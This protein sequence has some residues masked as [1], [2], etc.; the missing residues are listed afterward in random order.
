MRSIRVAS[1][2]LLSTAAFAL[3]APIASA[4]DGGTTPNVTSFGF[5]VSPT[6]VAAG[7]TV[8]L[9]A[10]GC[11][12]PLVKASSGI[13]DAVEL[14][15]GK[16]ATATVDA[17][18]KPG[19]QYEVTFECKG[20]KGTTTLTVAGHSTGTGT[21]TETGTTT[22]STPS[23]GVKAGLGG[24]AGGLNGTE[25]AAGSALLA[26]ALGGGVFLMRRRAGDQA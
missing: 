24:G 15:E 26:G 23:K 21:G 19:A 10:T 2:A 20:E 4:N 6:T 14:N 25:I 18:A 8:T 9:N 3:A 12:E 17:D 7:G 11:Q 13:F 22:P 5:T 16:P 1:V